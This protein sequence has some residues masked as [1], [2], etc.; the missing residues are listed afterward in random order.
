MRET[1]RERRT[2][3]RGGQGPRQLPWR[4][5]ENSFRP[6]EL[7]DAE[8]VERVHAASL[9]LL[10]ELGLEFQNHEALGILRAN[11]AV[12]D[13]ETGIVRFPPDLVESWVARAPSG[14]TV[15]S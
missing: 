3:E 12:V 8:Q 11:G 9:K 7:L 1:A 15:R 6:A 2:R 10:F 13:D 5:L 4:Q 14:F